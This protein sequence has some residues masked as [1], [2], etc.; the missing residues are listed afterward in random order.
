MAGLT[1]VINSYVLRSNWEW[2]SIKIL[3]KY[4]VL[5]LTLVVITVQTSKFV[6]HEIIMYLKQICQLPCLLQ[7][8]LQ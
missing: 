7:T 2:V 4:Y 5:V 6:L 1:N 3:I 8:E